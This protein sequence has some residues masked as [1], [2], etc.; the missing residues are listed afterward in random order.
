MSPA[1]TS[2]SADSTGTF[3][4]TD[5]ASGELVATL[6]IDGT[7]QVAA[8]VVRAREA[9]PRWAALGFA[10]RRECLLRWASELAR[11]SGELAD[12]ISRE[13]GKPHDDALLE[14]L[15]TLEHLRWAATN[16]RR[17]LRPRKVSSGLLMANHAASVEW[18]PLGVVAVIG[19][20]NYPVYTPN[21]SAAYALAAGNTVVF[22]PSEHT[23]AVGRYYAAAFARANPA[24]PEGVLTTATGAGETGEALCRAGVD[25][26]SFTGSSATGRKV[27]ATCAEALT[28][29]TV[30]CG[31]KDALIVAA[32]A[33]VPAAAEAAAFG[34]LGNSGQTC[35]GVER[36]YVHRAVR[37]E[38]L[39]QLRRKLD[40][41]RAG[42]S[43]GPMTIP[44]QLDVVRRH[45]A[46]ALDRG[47]EAVVGGADSVRPPYV[48]PVV[49]LVDDERS[50]AV[51]EE[52]FG[53]TITVR[54]VDSIDQ[55]VE[56][57]NGTR[58]GLAA[59]VFSRRR[60]PEIARRLRVGATSVNSVLGFGGIPELPFGG[61]GESGFGRIHGVP[62]I[63]AF[64]RSNSV[65]RQRFPVPGMNLMS[66]GR[67]RRAMAVVH[68]IIRLRHGRR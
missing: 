4:S 62:G 60:G 65:A 27:M 31:G 48:D 43:Y 67:G 2:G 5:P 24:A 11:N 14:L 20:W 35:A 59:S 23:P 46:D 39:G 61:A 26:V 16:A 57:A 42:T 17:A 8:A 55:A 6:P 30:E 45:I 44:S 38:F 36:I 33:D 7:D 18:H 21:G 25:A 53:P 54:T 51:Q 64:A 40:P 52:T 41:V 3:Q 47:A 1:T 32:D 28:P 15:L 34:A 58:F 56:L 63:R 50:A 68:R 49:L 66:F 29:V 9:A 19:P 22:K 37:D 13:C 10:E 12:L